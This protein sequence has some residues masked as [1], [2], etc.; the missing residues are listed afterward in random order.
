MEGTHR[1]KPRR[2]DRMGPARSMPP[3]LLNSVY[4]CFEEELF[5]PPRFFPASDTGAFQE[6]HSP[7]RNWAPLATKHPEALM[8]QRFVATHRSSSVPLPPSAFSLPLELFSLRLARHHRATRLRKPGGRGPGGKERYVAG[9][10]EGSLQNSPAP[11]CVS[12][13]MP[14]TDFPDST[15]CCGQ[16]NV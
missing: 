2:A 1:A 10:C 3:P 13:F 9:P 12:A 16:R 7:F 5:S 14:D 11:C 4:T 6:K 8:F 15:R